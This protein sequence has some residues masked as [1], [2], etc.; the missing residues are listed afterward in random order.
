MKITIKALLINVNDEQKQ[1]IDQL[2]TVF[3]SAVRYAFKRHFWKYQHPSIYHR[4]YQ[5]KPEK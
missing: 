2:M 4:N 3:C 5:R 1:A